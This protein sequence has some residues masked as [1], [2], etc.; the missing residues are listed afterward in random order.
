[1]AAS[2]LKLTN[3]AIGV[4]AGD[5]AVSDTTIT[6][7]A[8]HGSRF[9]S[10]SAGEWFPL[11]LMDDAGNM[12]II[13]VTERVTDTLT[14]TRGLEGTTAKEFLAGD[15]VCL[16][17]TAG[18]F[19]GEIDRM[20]ADIA[21]KAPIASPTFTGTPAAPTASP[22]TDTTQIATTAFVAA[23][24]S[25]GIASLIDS[26]PTALNTLNELA[27]ALD[28]DPN[29]ATTVTNALAGKVA[30]AGD[31]M[32]GL[33]KFAKG[34][35]IASATTVDLTSATGN[36]VTITGTTGISAFT[37]TSGQSMDVIFADALTLTHHA[38]N[39]NLPGGANYT[40][41]AGDRGRL[42]FDGTT[43]WVQLQR[44][45]GMAVAEP[46]NLL[47]VGQSWTNVTSSRNSGT[48][49]RNTTGKPIQVMVSFDVGSNSNA[50]QV[51]SDGST[52]LSLGDI[53]QDADDWDETVSVIIPNGHYI[54]ITADSIYKWLEL[55]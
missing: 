4:L 15:K 53:N 17:M 23:A 22:G 8:T 36:T 2:T 34:D 41:A 48:A 50:V 11:T 24:L 44:A 46:S 18:V 27:A 21:T 6:L 39:N 37:M 35:D 42:Y 20:D 30:K 28:D 49:Y 32:T 40:T 3:N 19:E 38:T 13:R 55:R 52:W 51:S 26:S 43:V 31:T 12:E 29:F 9:P 5:V 1:M 33:L 14:V 54:K 7:V 45:N 10:L 47:G 25:A 16:R